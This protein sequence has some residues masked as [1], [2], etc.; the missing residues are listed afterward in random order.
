MFSSG[1]RNLPPGECLRSL[2]S[3][4][5][6]LGRSTHKRCVHSVAISDPPAPRPGQWYGDTTIKWSYGLVAFF[7]LLRKLSQRVQPGKN[8][9]DRGLE[10]ANAVYAAVDELNQQLPGGVRVEKSLDAPL[11]GAAGK[12]ES[13]SIS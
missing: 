13:L 10:F 7:D 9:T 4:R 6:H 3:H 1:R 12:L 8:M 11:Y 5:S 2:Q